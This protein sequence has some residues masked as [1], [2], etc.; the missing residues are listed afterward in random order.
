MAQEEILLP[1][2]DTEVYPVYSSGYTIVSSLLAESADDISAG[3]DSLTVSGG[4]LVPP[5]TTLS[6][7]ELYSAS[8][9]SL[10]EYS[11]YE[12]FLSSP[13]YVTRYEFE[14]LSKLEF[15]QYALAIIIALLFLLFFKKNRSN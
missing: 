10:G 9:I 13:V 1:E 12:E 15:I 7:A 6:D 3:D 8:G 14:I 5:A 4:D 11:T 2:E